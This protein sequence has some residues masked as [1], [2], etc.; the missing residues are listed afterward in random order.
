MFFSS[1]HFLK[2]HMLMQFQGI[3]NRKLSHNS[4]SYQD[5]Y[6]IIINKYHITANFLYY[7][8]ISAYEAEL[9][10]SKIPYK[11][12]TSPW[13]KFNL[14]I[15]RNFSSICL[16]KNIINMKAKKNA[17][18]YLES[19]SVFSCPLCFTLILIYLDLIV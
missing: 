9:S 2:F 13:P 6:I 4:N 3:F 12:E 8:L 18:K 14:Y 5:A 7:F 1:L 17:V 10:I 15:L 19:Y 16:L 11:S